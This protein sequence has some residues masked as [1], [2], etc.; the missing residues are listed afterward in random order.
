[1]RKLIAAGLIAAGLAGA[2][3]AGAASAHAGS[4][5]FVSTTSKGEVLIS[6]KC[7]QTNQ[8]TTTYYHYSKK[9]GGY[10]KYVAPKITQ[11]Q[12]TTCHA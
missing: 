4:L 8:Y 6:P 12:S 2:G 3:V 9:A 7:Y 11:T 1:M 10:V 5:P